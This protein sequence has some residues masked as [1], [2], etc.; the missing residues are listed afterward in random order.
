MTEEQLELAH[1]LGSGP[2]G[3]VY[4]ACNAET[5]VGLWVHRLT[6][7]LARRQSL[8]AR[9]SRLALT[10]TPGFLKVRGSNLVGSQGPFF[11]ITEASERT[12]CT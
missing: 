1:V 7:D 10:N 2:D 5:G 6:A 12:F 3:V 8:A 11:V 4:A 9:V